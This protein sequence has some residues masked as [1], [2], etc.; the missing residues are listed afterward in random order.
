[1]SVGSVL[2]RRLVSSLKIW[3]RNFVLSLHHPLCLW[4]I[5]CLLS[6]TPGM[7]HALQNQ[8][9]PGMIFLGPHIQNY[10]TVCTSDYGSLLSRRTD[11][12]SHKQQCLPSFLNLLKLRRFSAK[13][14]RKSS[15]C[16]AHR[17]RFRTTRRVKVQARCH[18]FACWIY[19]FLAS[20]TSTS[21]RLVYFLMA[22]TWKCMRQ[23]RWW[24]ALAHTL[25]CKANCQ[26]LPTSSPPVAL[27]RYL[28]R[29]GGTPRGYLNPLT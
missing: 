2:V 9:V 25:P 16:S 22:S 28:T 4:K 12:L 15:K 5:F 23:T 20:A 10:L 29:Q 19:A 18:L 1:M 24:R 14:I 7:S 13:P 27:S 3:V 26:I 17:S 21:D 8:R 11:L 6:F